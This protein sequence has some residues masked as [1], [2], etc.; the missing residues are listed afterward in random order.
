MNKEL[1]IKAIKNAQECLS[2]IVNGTDYNEE[3]ATEGISHLLL[4]L[5][6][7]EK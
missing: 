5:N 7:I 4:A 1:V 6:E 2:E 3:M